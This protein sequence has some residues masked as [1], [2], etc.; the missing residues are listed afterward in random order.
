MTTYGPAELFLEPAE[1][2]WLERW[3]EIKWRLPPEW[4]NKYVFFTSGKGPCKNINNH[5][6]N[7]WAAM[8]LPGTPQF[9][10]LRSSIATLV[11]TR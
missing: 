4:R 3:L 6:Q 9:G 1:F 7:A 5:M 11:S 2:R 8:G 10:S